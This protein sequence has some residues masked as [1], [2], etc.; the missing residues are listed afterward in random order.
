MEY[1]K[2][3]PYLYLTSTSLLFPKF[4]IA[5]DKIV[6]LPPFCVITVIQGKIYIGMVGATFYI[7]NFSRPKYRKK[8]H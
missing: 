2:T 5:L 6:A 8:Q 7:R 3:C 4:N 1:P